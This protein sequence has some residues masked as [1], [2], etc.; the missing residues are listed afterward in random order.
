MTRFKI[1]DTVLVEGRKARIVWL[2]E[3]PNEIEAIDEYIVEF[4]DKHRQFLT[5]SMLVE[6]AEPMHH[7]EH[8][9]DPCYG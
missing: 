8:D 9:S 6:N 3:N 2:S 7:R 5:S 4:E 1:G